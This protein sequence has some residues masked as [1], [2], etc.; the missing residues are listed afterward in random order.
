MKPRLTLTEREASFVEESLRRSRL[1]RSPRMWLAA[2]SS[3]P[4]TE[5]RKSSRLSPLPRN[6]LRD[7]RTKCCEWDWAV[8]KHGVMESP[9][10]EPRA[11]PCHCVKSQSLDLTGSHWIRQGVTT[12]GNQARIVDA[13]MIK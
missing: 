7:Q 6:P 2:S 1:L 11:E 5:A 9:Y 13:N 3:E 12:S 4:S 8:G 10:I